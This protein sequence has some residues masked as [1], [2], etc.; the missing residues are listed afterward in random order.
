MYLA[1]THPPAD[2][3]WLFISVSFFSWSTAAIMS[4]LSEEQRRRMEEN[5][6]KALA[7]RAAKLSPQ[8]QPAVPNS[9]TRPYVPPVASSVPQPKL[10]STQALIEEKRQKALAL[11]ASK[12]SP[13]KK[14]PS[15]SGPPETIAQTN[16]DNTARPPQ[17]LSTGY[18]DSLCNNKQSS[19]STFQNA[20]SSSS[21]YSKNTSKP[22]VPNPT[23]TKPTTSA[24]NSLFTSTK[25][26]SVSNNPSKPG[27]YTSEQAAQ[28]ASNSPPK[29][30]VANPMTGTCVLI[31]RERFEVQVGYHGG[32]IQMF[33]SLETKQYGE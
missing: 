26:S 25:S 27:L 3:P 15:T 14:P 20:S 22:T 28:M 16:N 33:K 5:R 4:G 12:M 8:K 32:L 23:L 13:Q 29:K 30:K 19:S 24:M 31:S 10:T 2:N 17:P 7:R 9:N 21:F 6:Q 18:P 11:R 1:H